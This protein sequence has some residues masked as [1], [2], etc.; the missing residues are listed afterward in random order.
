MIITLY[1]DFKEVMFRKLITNEDSEA[2]ISVVT[3]SGTV[4]TR[5]RVSLMGEF[6]FLSLQEVQVIP[7]LYG[8]TNYL[9][10]PMGLAFN[11][12]T[13]NYLAFIQVSDS[14]SKSM[15]E[16]YISD[17]SLKYGFVESIESLL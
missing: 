5:L 1:D 12:T 11:S 16:T 14:D 9:D 7:A 10:I 13:I 17:F 4:A 15:I 6:R 8:P 3:P 2:I